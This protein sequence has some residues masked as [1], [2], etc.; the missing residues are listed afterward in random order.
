ME[1]ASSIV[2]YRKASSGISGPRRSQGLDGEHYTIGATRS[3]GIFSLGVRACARAL[4]TLGVWAGGTKEV[5]GI[6]SHVY[7]DVIDPY[8]HGR[9]AS[10]SSEI[11]GHIEHFLWMLYEG[12]PLL[13]HPA[14]DARNVH[15]Q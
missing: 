1:P 14:P 6:H 10:Q 15:H 5:G 12:H 9:F 7:R 3:A 8:R 13:A 11:Y 2:S 4:L